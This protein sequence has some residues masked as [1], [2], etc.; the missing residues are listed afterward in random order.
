MWAIN[1]SDLPK[2]QSLN[3]N[4]VFKAHVSFPSWQ[5]SC[6]Q[7]YINARR[8]TYLEDEGRFIFGILPDFIL[9]VSSF[10]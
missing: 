8:V 5:Y 3:K 1:Q 6:I 9:C 7:S 2:L 4:S 10:G